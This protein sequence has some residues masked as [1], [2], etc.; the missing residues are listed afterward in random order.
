MPSVAVVTPPEI[1][2]EARVGSTL[3]VTEPVW[4]PADATTAYQW[5]RDGASIPGATSTELLLGT[6]DVGKTIAVQ[7]I[8][9]K[10]DHT[11]GTSTSAPTAVVT[12]I[13]ARVTVRGSSTK[14]GALRLSIEVAAAGEPAPS[15]SVSVKQ[16]SKVLQGRVT[17]TRGTASYV[18]TGIKPGRYTYS[19][20]YAGTSRIA[21]ASGT[22][23]VAIKG[24]SRPSIVLK[25]TASPGRVGI[26][27]SVTAPGQPPL[28]GTA[29]VKEGR[30]TLK[31]T[32]KVVKGKAS[33]SARGVKSG[34][35]TYV[36]GYRGTSQVHS[37]SRSIT[38]RV[39]APA[40][41][42]SYANCA[43]MQ[44]VHPH[45][46]GRKGAKDRTS[47]TPVTTFL[48]NTKLYEY[49]D[50]KAR[51]KGEK[52]LDRDNDGVACEKR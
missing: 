24:K 33:F 18:A 30:K 47:G 8:G 34:R 22:G 5:V 27:I 21:P 26:G 40:K 19:V 1:V 50:G 16:G 2:G 10:V 44:K 14:V 20:S 39:P 28:G 7:A 31:S 41:L 43:A 42:V 15:G 3:S 36:V 9:S 37:G 23:S 11:D 29:Y 52:D 35:H 46:V 13:P 6:A 17:L 49:N 51:K 12:R 4:S 48:V 45:G 25:P 38:V 32:I